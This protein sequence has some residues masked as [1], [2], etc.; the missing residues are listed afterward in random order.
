MP[1]TRPWIS[2]KRNMIQLKCP[3]ILFGK[4]L[5]N[6]LNIDFIRGFFF[7]HETRSQEHYLNRD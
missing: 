7:L 1:H 4:D 6:L 2:K 5:L 3:K